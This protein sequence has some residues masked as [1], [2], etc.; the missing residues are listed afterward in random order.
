MLIIQPYGRLGNNIFQIIK[1]VHENLFRY[2]HRSIVLTILKQS[3]PRIFSN[4][5]D[6]ITFD[7]PEDQTPIRGYFW[8]ISLIKVEETMNIINK[9]I[10]PYIDYSLPDTLGIN[11]EKDLIIHI[12]SGDV[13]QENFDLNQ[14]VQPPYSF[15]Q[16]VLETHKFDNVFILSENYNIN[17][18]IPKLFKNYKNIKFLSNDI[19]TDFKIMLNSK[20]F[21]NSNSTLSQIVNSISL[22]KELIIST[23]GWTRGY[24]NFNF[25]HYDY[26]SYYEHKNKTFDEKIHRL[27]HC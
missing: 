15:Y 19:S 11:F 8:D 24:S 6:I 2:K 5:P 13:F 10:K 1:C 22:S 18:V 12:R 23:Q 3:Q 4:F 17:P 7:F 27:L 21:V 16:K 14:Y 26:S 20:Y 25:E 9:Y